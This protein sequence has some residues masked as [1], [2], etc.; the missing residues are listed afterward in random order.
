[1]SFFFILIKKNTYYT[2][3]PQ[4]ADTLYCRQFAW[5]K[6]DKKSYKIYLCNVDTYK[7]DALSC[8]FGIHIKKVQLYIFPKII[9]SSQ[10]NQVL[11]RYSQQENIWLDMRNLPLS[12]WRALWELRDSC[13]QIRQLFQLPWYLYITELCKKRCF[14]NL[15]HAEDS[16]SRLGY[17]I[18]HDYTMFCIR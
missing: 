9:K 8:P 10:Q 2:V 15:L 4:L 13:K 5:S 12:I 11:G 14:V 1:M 6:R 16:C 3:K 7:T 18:W 17:L